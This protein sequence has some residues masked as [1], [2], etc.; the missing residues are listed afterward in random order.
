MTCTRSG[1]IIV[2]GQLL[3][4]PVPTARMHYPAALGTVVSRD[5]GE[6]WNRIPLPPGQNGVNIEGGITQLRD[7][8]MLALDTYIVPGEKPREWPA[9]NVTSPAMIG[10]QWTARST[11]TLIFQ[12]PFTRQKTMRVVRTKRSACMR[13]RNAQRRFADHLLRVAGRRSY[14]E[15]L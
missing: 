15:R 13:I 2:Q 11:F 12:A 8:T 7:G 4:K 14:A 3:Q 9:D 10:G 1:A 6:T 5:G